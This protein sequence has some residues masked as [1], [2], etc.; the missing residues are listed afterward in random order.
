MSDQ[1]VAATAATLESSS[2]FSLDRYF[3]ISQRGSTVAT[4]VLAGV[5]TFL[6][7]FGHRR[8]LSSSG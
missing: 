1:K 6:A 3:Q 8:M 4:E 7:L 2:S 5:S